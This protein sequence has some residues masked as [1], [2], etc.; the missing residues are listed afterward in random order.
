MKN[1]L[2]TFLLAAASFGAVSNASGQSTTPQSL[3]PDV[4]E[5]LKLQKNLDSLLKQDVLDLPTTG[6]QMDVRGVS[7]SRKFMIIR[8]NLPTRQ[9]EILGAQESDPGSGTQ[10]DKFKRRSPR[11]L[12]NAAKMIDE[13]KLEEARQKMLE[14]PADLN[15]MRYVPAPLIQPATDF[16]VPEA[17]SLTYSGPKYLSENTTPTKN[18]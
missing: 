8:S 6:E 3:D 1:N 12:Q 5:I 7:A 2:F 9:R 11:E 13:Q 15:S 16:V 4:L 14:Q 18:V 17:G 10:I